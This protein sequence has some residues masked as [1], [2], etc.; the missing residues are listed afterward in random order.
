MSSDPRKVPLHRPIQAHGEEVRELAL[1]EP[2]GKDLRLCGMPYRVT[3]GEEVVID[4]AVMARLIVSLAAIPMSS[5]DQLSAGDFQEV[6][7]VVMGFFRPAPPVA[8]APLTIS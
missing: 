2:S 7:G 8:P 5:V 6:T 1:R 4:S 3:Q